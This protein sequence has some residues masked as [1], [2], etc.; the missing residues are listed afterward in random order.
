MDKSKFDFFLFRFMG[1][2]FK[3]HILTPNN[4]MYC[5]NNLVYKHEKEPLECLCILLKT[6]G[7]ELDQVY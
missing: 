5:I 6:A 4:I 2:L 7:K 3:Q 1:E